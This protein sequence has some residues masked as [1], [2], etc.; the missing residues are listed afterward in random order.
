MG[1]EVARP[2]DED[3]RCLWVG[4]PGEI[5]PDGARA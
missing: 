2:G 1:G 4:L 3:R 5:L